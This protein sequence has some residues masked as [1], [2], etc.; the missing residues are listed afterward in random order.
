MTVPSNVR[1]G[2][3]STLSEAGIPGCTRPMS[4]SSTNAES[5]TLSRLAILRMTVPPPR[6]GLEITVPS[7]ASSSRIVPAMGA[8]TW[9]SSIASCAVRK[10]ASAVATADWA[11]ALASLAWS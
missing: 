7:T 1:P 8:R 6:V 10:F 2:N 11:T 3:A 5:C 9:V 4:V